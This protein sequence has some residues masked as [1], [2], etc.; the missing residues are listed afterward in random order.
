MHK[1][2]ASKSTLLLME[3]VMVIFVF[4]LCAAVC[5]SL[6]GAAQKMTADSNHL[7]HAVTVSRTAAN[8]YK[9]ANGD[10]QQTAYLMDVP[11]DFTE[12][13]QLT[14]YYDKHWNPTET[15]SEDGFYLRI[16]ALTDSSAPL[17]EAD[18]TV[19]HMDQT[20]IFQMQVKKVQVKNTVLHT[21]GELYGTE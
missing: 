20:V 2:K 10:L 18:L 17:Q 11:A 19:C 3:L 16:H 6:F 21:G 13:L 9:A 8:C 5:L 1:R 4:A 12:P 14:V 7:N 15:I